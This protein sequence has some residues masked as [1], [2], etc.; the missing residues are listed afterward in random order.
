LEYVVL[1]GSD[2]IGR[3]IVLTFMKQGANVVFTY[4][5]NEEKALKLQGLSES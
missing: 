5:S 1:G 3:E 4:L 2:G